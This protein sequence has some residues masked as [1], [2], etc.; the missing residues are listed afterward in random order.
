MRR[1]AII[2]L[3]ST[4]AVVAATAGPATPKA[5]PQCGGQLWRLKTFSDL[6]RGSVRLPARSTTIEAIAERAFPH[7][8]PRVRNTP[9]QRQVW[10]VVA[11]VVEY[12][13]DGSAL[14]LILFDD[15]SYMNAVVPAPWCLSARTR[16]RRAIE[17][18]WESF[19]KKCGRPTPAWQP[20]GAVGY[21]EGVGFWSSRFAGR[22]RA[23]VNGAELHPVTGFRPIAGCGS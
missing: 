11:Q 16:D 8:L 19:F 12:R 15:G 10:Q 2:A 4:F 13:L 20:L 14:R 1:I 7:P 18:T 5:G 21:V 22:R 6:G 3:I 17:L 9:F 23:A